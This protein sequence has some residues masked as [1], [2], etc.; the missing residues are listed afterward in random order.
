MCVRMRAISQVYEKERIETEM[1]YVELKPILFFLKC[2]FQ[3]C[4]VLKLM[5]YKIEMN[6]A[7]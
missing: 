5:S 1:I 4:L 6:V 2:L 7:A 3:H